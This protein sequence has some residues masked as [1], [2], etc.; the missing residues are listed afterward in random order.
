MCYDRR[1]L[2]SLKAVDNAYNSAGDEL[3]AEFQKK[4]PAVKA[5]WREYQSYGFP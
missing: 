3:I 5:V 4:I 2:I 1:Y